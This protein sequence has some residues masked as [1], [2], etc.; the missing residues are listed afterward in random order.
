MNSSK[1]NASLHR[2]L[3]GE[4][5]KGMEFPPE[6]KSTEDIMERFSEFRLLQRASGTRAINMKTSS[7][8]IDAVSLWNRVESTKGKAVSRAMRQHCAVFSLLVEPF[9]RY[10]GAIKRKDRKD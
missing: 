8:D 6:T 9:L 10:T 4:H 3:V 5:E 7:N 1:L 2:G